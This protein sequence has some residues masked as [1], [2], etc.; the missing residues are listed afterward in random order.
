MP[1]MGFHSKNDFFTFSDAFFLIKTRLSRKNEIG[2][3]QERFMLFPKHPYFLLTGIKT[4]EWW[5]ACQNEEIE[6]FFS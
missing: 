6:E 4:N 1:N 2:Y 5:L 3:E